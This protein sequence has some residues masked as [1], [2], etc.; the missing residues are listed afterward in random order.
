MSGHSRDGTEWP[1]GCDGGVL[2]YVNR[3]GPITT[4]RIVEE[5]GIWSPDEVHTSL[6]SLENDG[7]IE[8]REGSLTEHGTTRRVW[9]IE[10]GPEQEADR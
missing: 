5:C 7:F 4:N 2:D 10:T 8:S 1:S 6:K 9:Y 3:K